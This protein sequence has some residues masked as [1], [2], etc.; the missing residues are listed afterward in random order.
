MDIFRKYFGLVMIQLIFV[1]VIILFTTAVRCFDSA[2]FEILIGIY[3]KYS[4]YDVSTSLV[5]DGE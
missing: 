1:L 3:S 4:D 5:Y 2:N